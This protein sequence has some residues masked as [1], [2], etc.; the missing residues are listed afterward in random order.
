MVDYESRLLIAGLF[1]P[2]STVKD[3]LKQI[4][5]KGPCEYI[6]HYRQTVSGN[7]YA[8]LN[9][10][11]VRLDINFPPK[12][13]Y[14]SVELS[15]SEAEDQR[16]KQESQSENLGI[17]SK[18]EL[19]FAIDSTRAVVESGLRATLCSSLMFCLENVF[20]NSQPQKRLFI[21]TQR[22]SQIIAIS[23]KV[24]NFRVQKVISY[25]RSIGQP[26]FTTE[27]VFSIFSAIF[28]P[29]SL[30]TDQ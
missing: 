7:N 16:I 20:M 14:G 21:R 30:I 29:L 8:Q 6:P 10:N 28:A 15:F 9:R 1:R 12:L 3:T 17:A 4:S 25:S 27:V 5:Q 23:N 2:F 22:L 19:V 18:H 13:Y 26:S 11:G 24:H